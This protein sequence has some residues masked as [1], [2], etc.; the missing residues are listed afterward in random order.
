MYAH[1]ADDKNNNGT[2]DADE[3]FKVI[4]K[5]GAN[6]LKTVD[7]LALGAPVET[8]SPT[9]SSYKFNGWTPTFQ[10]TVRAEDA[11]TDSEIIYTASWT[12]NG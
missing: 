1:W 8:Y 9:K 10:S 11:N 3:I 7:S 5:D 4:F 2:A 12:Y 6:V